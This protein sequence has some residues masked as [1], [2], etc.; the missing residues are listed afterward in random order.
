MAQLCPESQ[1]CLVVACH[2]H[3]APT[4][5]ALRKGWSAWLAVSR[6]IDVEY[7]YT[8]C[9]YPYE[10]IGLFYQTLTCILRKPLASL[11]I[12]LSVQGL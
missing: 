3:R 7:T 1:N 12:Q 10:M 11:G 9:V 4:L 5:F 2:L 8:A 6:S